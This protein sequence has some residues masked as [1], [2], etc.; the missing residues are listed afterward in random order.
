MKAMHG[1][2]ATNDK[3]DAHTMAPLLRGGRRPDAY[4]SSR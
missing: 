2:N 3:I 4:S 1:G